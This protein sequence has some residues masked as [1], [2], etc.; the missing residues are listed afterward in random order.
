MTARSAFWPIAGLALIGAHIALAFGASYLI[1]WLYFE[2][3]V[4]W[5]PDPVVPQIQA[6]LATISMSITSLI[7]VPA[8]LGARQ[9]TRWGV[10]VAIGWPL[11]CVL[12]AFLPPLILFWILLGIFLLMKPN[13]KALP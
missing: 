7:F 2:V 9:R 1:F 5:T 6:V 12:W 8:G 10:P 13:P 3:G 11:A 4:K